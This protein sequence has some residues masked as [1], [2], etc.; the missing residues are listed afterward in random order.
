PLGLEA[1]LV[2]FSGISRCFVGGGVQSQ[3]FN[4]A[5][6]LHDNN[7][8][9]DIAAESIQVH[10]TDDTEVKTSGRGS[11]LTIPQ[12]LSWNSHTRVRASH[13][14]LRRRVAASVEERIGPRS[15]LHAELAVERC[16]RLLTHLV[17]A[18]PLNQYIVWNS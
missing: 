8:H 16:I 17:V 5:S 15:Q 10:E 11:Q 3:A 6:S 18:N 2:S 7:A 13:A 14:R 4:L 1:F 9:V 12:L